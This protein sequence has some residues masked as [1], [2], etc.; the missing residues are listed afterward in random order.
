MN[1]TGLIDGTHT[2]TI[3][4]FDNAGNFVDDTASFRVTIFRPYVSIII[5]VISAIAV[6]GVIFEWERKRRKQK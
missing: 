3:R 1:L 4:A 2:I 5:I 6:V